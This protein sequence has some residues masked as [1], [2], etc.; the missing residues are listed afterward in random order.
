MAVL[1]TF[2]VFVLSAIFLDP[3][4]A[5]AY[6]IA[7]GCFA[8]LAL[9]GVTAFEVADNPLNGLDK[10]IEPGSKIKR[11]E[12]SPGI[13]CTVIL[14]WPIFILLGI[15]MFFAGKFRSGTSGQ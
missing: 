6:F 13:Y 10:T 12:I 7:G 3:S 2:L 15:Y 9:D 5:I 14:L 8:L 4:L 11:I 1:S